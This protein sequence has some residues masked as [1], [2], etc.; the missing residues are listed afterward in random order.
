ML[1][2]P[3]FSEFLAVHEKKGSRALW[4]D[5][6]AVVGGGTATLQD[7]QTSGSRGKK[8]PAPEAGEDS[9]VEEADEPEPAT[10]DMDVSWRDG[11]L[12]D[13]MGG[14]EHGPELCRSGAVCEGLSLKTI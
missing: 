7:D 13:C 11:L 2:D 4:A 8:P 1:E 5:D 3:A 10:A 14:L 12:R 9:G 6:A